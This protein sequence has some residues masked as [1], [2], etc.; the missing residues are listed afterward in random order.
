MRNIPH[1]CP[2]DKDLAILKNTIATIGPNSAILIDEMV[3]PDMGAHAQS[4]EQD[5]MMMTKLSSMK[6]TQRK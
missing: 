4:T 3:T 5:I 6:S 2:K 1:G